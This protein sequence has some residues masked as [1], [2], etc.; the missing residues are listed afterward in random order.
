MEREVLRVKAESKEEAVAAL[1]RS[2]GRLKGSLQQGPIIENDGIVKIDSTNGPEA[3]IAL[4]MLI[5]WFKGYAKT[6]PVNE[7]VTAEP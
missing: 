1:K 2:F 4:E 6:G 7:C 3:S 5:G